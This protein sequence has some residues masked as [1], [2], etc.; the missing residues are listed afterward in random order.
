MNRFF[1]LF[2]L[3]TL[4]LLATLAKAGTNYQYIYITCVDKHG[5]LIGA[6][7]L[8]HPPAECFYLKA[9]LFLTINA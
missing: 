9:P 6:T 8:K 5:N 4:C 3:T 2:T 7:P 1:R